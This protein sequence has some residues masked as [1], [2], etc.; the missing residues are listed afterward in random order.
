MAID[1]KDSSMNML[2]ENAIRFTNVSRVFTIIH[3]SN[4][5]A[6]S[7]YVEKSVQIWIHL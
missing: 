6:I 2:P 4:A 1:T 5:E 7:K 3:I